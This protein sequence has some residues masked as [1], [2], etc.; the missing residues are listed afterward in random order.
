MADNFL[1]AFVSGLKC[2]KTGGI[3][4]TVQEL[5]ENQ[6]GIP[7]RHYA[8]QRLFGATGL[9]IQEFH[10][11]QGD[12]GEGKST[13]LFDLIGDTCG[14]E[15]D[16][17]LGGVA[18][19]Y[20]LEQK[21]SPTILHSILVNHGE[22]ALLA[23][24]LRLGMTL[25]DAMKDV[26]AKGGALDIYRKA[27]PRRD[28]P[29]ILA[30]DSI[31]GAANADTMEKLEADGAV[32]KGFSDKQHNMKYWC[33][34]QGAIFA[35]DNIPVVVICIN[36]EK[37]VLGGTSYGPPQK[38]ITGGKAQMFKDGH[39]ISVKKKALASGDGNVVT[40]RTTKSSFCD[41]RKIEVEFRWNR[42]GQKTG[43]A[44]EARFLWAL[45]S[46]RCIADPDNGVGEIRD[47]C[48]VKISDRDLVTCPQ[49]GLKSVTPEEFEAA[50]FADTK[51]LEQL[52]VYQKIERLR[53]VTEYADW[54]AGKD[55]ASDSPAEP[56]AAKKPAAKS[57][58]KA[59]TAAQAPEVEATP[60]FDAAEGGDNG[61]G[62]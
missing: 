41:P 25:G 5:R 11:I 28:K 60:L 15:E 33:E 53:S 2:T 39:M 30:F 46:A 43:D 21:I 61:T 56:V 47:I 50:L 49:L 32:G 48:D 8:Q 13:L 10:S 3:A 17:G 1:D 62:Q 26:N 37:E 9:R 52:Y 59:K 36:Q 55:K 31:G 42:H 7:L 23:C 18:V 38:T 57:K 12:K 35:R 44:Y 6:F 29:L 40:L 14:A 27:C 4:Y 24:M 51:L 45:A 19:L 22:R 58:A 16:G 54:L 34:N 20:E